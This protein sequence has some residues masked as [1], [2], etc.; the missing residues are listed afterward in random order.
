MISHSRMAPNALRR[1][2]V[3]VVVDDV[4]AV[5]EDGSVNRRERTPEEMERLTQLVRDAIGFDVRRGD[6]VRVI[7][8]AFLAPEPVE[9]LPAPAIW[10]EAWFWDIIKQVGGVLLVLLLI[11]GVLKPRLTA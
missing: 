5:A 6:S 8:S 2:S 4:V 10:E 1:L 11:F 3:A 9:E 7:N